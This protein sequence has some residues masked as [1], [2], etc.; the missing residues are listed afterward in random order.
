S[1]GSSNF[2]AI[3]VSKNTLPNAQ[4]INAK[5]TEKGLSKLSIIVVPFALSENKQI[6]SSYLI[7]KGEIDGNGNSYFDLPTNQA[8]LKLPTSLK[9]VLRKPHGKVYKTINDFKKD[10]P[11]D[12]FLITVGDIVS[13]NAILNIKLPEI[14]VIDNKTQR[15]I[16]SDQGTFTNLPLNYVKFENKPGTINRQINP[17]FKNAVDIYYKNKQ[18][19]LFVIRGEEDLLA[20]PIMVFAPLN[21]VVLYGLYN[22]GIVAVLITT[23]K[24]KQMRKLLG[25]FN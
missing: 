9:K 6:I 24:K 19:T 12:V 15:K 22:Q 11:Q 4:L 3:F 21:S 18:K 13:K 1:L 8:D 20:L 2:D 14:M 7:R 10:L 17:Q 5:R 16:I 23:S 25:Q